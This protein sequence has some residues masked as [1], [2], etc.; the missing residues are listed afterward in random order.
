MQVTGTMTWVSAGPSGVFA[1]NGGNIYFLQ[2]SRGV[3]FPSSD[4][5]SEASWIQ[6]FMNLIN[7]LC[8]AVK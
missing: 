1:I 7:N 3:A 2:N 6:V 4:L 8:Y 5:V